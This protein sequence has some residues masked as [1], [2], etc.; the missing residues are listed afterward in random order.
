MEKATGASD[1]PDKLL[2]PAVSEPIRVLTVIESLGRGGAERLLV[3]MD[4]HLDHDRFSHR[5]VSLFRP[6][7]LA[8]ELE[9][10]GTPVTLFE[11]PGPSALPTAIRRLR[12]VVRNF[13]PHVVHTHLFAANVAGRLAA[14]GRAR[15]VATLHNP[16]YGSDAGSGVRFVARTFLDRAT[17]H[18]VSNR[19]LAVSEHVRQDFEQRMGFQHIE[20]YPNAVDVT[21]L[22][23][24]GEVTARE[25]V[26]STLGYGPDEFVVLHVGRM[27]RQKGQD[28]LVRAFAK[29]KER[30]PQSR[31]VLVGGGAEL[32]SLRAQVTTLELG[33]SVDFVGQVADVV[34]YMLAADAFAFP[35]RFE[36]FGIA[37]V[38]AMALGLPSVVSRIPGLDEV[39][40]TATS[41]FVPEENEE[42]LAGALVR[43][44][45]DPVLR[46]RLADGAR[47]RA[48]TFDAVPAVKRLEE[49]YEAE[50]TLVGWVRG[51][52]H[53]Q[54]HAG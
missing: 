19:L 24:Q 52:T 25:G 34:P 12:R 32:E 50:A 15:A 4:R 14:W 42:A 46:G 22:H 10:R 13:R 36:A 39:A 33:Q 29:V 44:A 49:V 9:D 17:G 54:F 27:H 3:T 21:G 6:N 37:L 30:V 23:R 26:R 43:L 40:T 38:E 31:L 20:L 28:V 51:S 45:E 11:L 2:V 8:H 1:G 35:S 18:M 41:I 47:A 16:D 5:V 7:P 53:A 48:V